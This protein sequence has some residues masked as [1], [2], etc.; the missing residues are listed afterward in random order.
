[1][2]DPRDVLLAIATGRFDDHLRAIVRAVSDRIVLIEPETAPTPPPVSP[3]P[4]RIGA[5]TIDDLGLGV[6]VR[7]NAHC[8]T[9]YLVGATARVVGLRRTKVVVKLDKPKGRFVRHT[10]DGPVSAD[11]TVPPAILELI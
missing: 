2:T 7:F 9:K 1:M 10:P 6:E 4:S 3:R 11:I 8:G 5:L